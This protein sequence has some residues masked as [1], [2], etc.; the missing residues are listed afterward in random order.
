LQY[1]A[2]YYEQKETG[3]F[4]YKNAFSFIIPRMLL[5]YNPTVNEHLLQLPPS[6]KVG[7]SITDR[8]G[9]AY[10]QPLISYALRAVAEFRG[11]VT[12][13]SLEVQ[14][15]REI[16]LIPFTE[17]GPPLATEDFPGEY[18]STSTKSLA[19]TPFG[20]LFGEMSIS[21]N[22]PSP[23]RF[24]DVSPSAD[25]LGY[26]RIVLRRVDATA[27]N[28]EP[29]R[30]TCTIRSGIHVKMLSST[31]PLRG[32]PSYSMLKTEKQLRLRAS[33]IDLQTR[34]IDAHS[35]DREGAHQPGGDREP[36]ASIWAT[37]LIL[38][39]CS[40]RL[41]P[42]FCSTL[43]ALRYA[44]RV[45][46]D[47]RGMYHSPFALEVPLQVLYC[48]E[49]GNARDLMV[50][51]HYIQQNVHDTSG[52]SGILQV[53]SADIMVSF[54]SIKASQHPG[55]ETFPPAYDYN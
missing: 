5:P 31:M 45:R 46:L 51:D 19:K 22:E 16:K 34:K 10:M 39:I 11:R 29:R 49:E 32:M 35:W 37:T 6:L 2:G 38:P 27:S 18:T 13:P 33:C 3:L 48:M 42:T 40:R 20:G 24:T 55:L 50:D 53:G 28:S 43:A 7:D 26:L 23:L 25:T 36:R 9:Q 15:T 1:E 4:I 14:D 30:L 21:M 12:E 44:L 47:I 17:I 8:T 54:H 52:V 41:P